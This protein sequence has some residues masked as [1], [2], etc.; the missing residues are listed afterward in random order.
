MVYVLLQVVLLDDGHND[1]RELC[2]GDAYEVLDWLSAYLADNV[3][4]NVYY[5]IVPEVSYHPQ[6]Q[7]A[8]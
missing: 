7:E 5:K 1:S 3:A 6:S 8:V 2:R 4:D